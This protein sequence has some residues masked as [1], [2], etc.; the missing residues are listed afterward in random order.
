[1]DKLKFFVLDECDKLVDELDMRSQIQ[2]IF[3]HT[4]HEKQVMMFSA[5]LSKMSRQVCKKFTLNSQD[6]FID[7]EKK[8]VL[9][10]LQQ[11]TVELKENEKNRKLIDILDAVQFNQCMIFVSKTTRCKAL[12]SLLC[13]QSFPSIAVYGGL[14]QDER[15]KKY[16]MFK[17]GE[18]RIMVSTNSQSRGVDFERVNLVFNY[19]MAESSD[20]YLHRVGRAGRF[21]TKGAAISFV[22]TQEDTEVME[23]VA[24][25]F[26]VKIKALPDT[27]D[28]SLLQ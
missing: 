28:D 21:G 24:S 27:I 26:I 6:V 22:S 17:K 14:P 3:R 4:P 13:D 15:I 8:M 18:K 20:T 23:K 7:D 16:K 11:F 5:T 19:D 1:M 2:D 25:R 12:N 9:E 10:G